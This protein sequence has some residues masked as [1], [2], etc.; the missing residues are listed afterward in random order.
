MA[1]DGKSGQGR[2]GGSESARFDAA[3]FERG[4]VF[5]L[6]MAFNR[7]FIRGYHKLE[8][9]GPCTVPSAGGCIIASNHTSGLD[10]MMIQSVVPRPIVWM[11]AAEFFEVPGLAWAWR[12]GRVIPVQRGS[13]D[14]GA[15]RRAMRVV[16]GGGVIGIF[17]E[18]GI[19]AGR[20][21]KPFRAGV[22]AMATRLGAPVVP[23]RLAGDQ[24]G[25]PLV[26]AYLLPQQARIAFSPPIL[27][28]KHETPEEFT[29]RLESTVRSLQS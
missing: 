2:D 4:R 28:R 19:G 15:L 11:M 7:P 8:L 18:G 14:G 3:E 24:C 23:I 6:L 21:I 13:A 22:G 5:R 10:P 25:Q 12:V 16:K 9:A 27:A 17:P 20:T 26:A 29:R 1:E